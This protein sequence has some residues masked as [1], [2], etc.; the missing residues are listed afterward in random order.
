MAYYRGAM[1][2][3]YQA[4]FAAV[5]ALVER[6]VRTAEE[7][8]RA[9]KRRARPAPCPSTVAIVGRHAADRPGRELFAL[10]GRVAAALP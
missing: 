4:A 3:H 6:H 10:I 7:A 5:H 1:N 2:A 9:R 8:G